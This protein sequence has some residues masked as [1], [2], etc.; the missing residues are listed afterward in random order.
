MKT[1]IIAYLSSLISMLA[2]DFVWLNLMA[3]RFY[4]KYIGHLMSENPNFIVA[5]IFFLIYAAGLSLLVIIPSI[6]QNYSNLKIFALSA[7]L[8]FV[9]YATYD[10]TNQATLKDWPTLV[11]LVD[12]AWGALLTGTVGLISVLV[13][14]Y[15]I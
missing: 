3:K 15:F 10:L 6:E 7:L 13:T 5:G 11:T 12:L 1:Y 14:K 4:L 8:G 2:I 9:C